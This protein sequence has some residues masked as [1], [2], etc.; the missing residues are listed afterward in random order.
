MTSHDLAAS[1]VM[2]GLEG[3]SV[4]DCFVDAYRRTPFAGVI[5]FGR[6]VESLS[7]VRA[8]TDELRAL[9]T[10]PPL[11]AIDQEGGRVARLRDGVEEL[12]P[13]MALGAARSTELSE[14]AGEQLAFDVRRAG[15][16]ID[17]APVL[18]LAVDARNTVIGA[19]S[20]GSEPRAVATVAR[21][22]LRGM[23]RGGMKGVAKHF[24]GHGATSEDSHLA[25]PVIE[26]SEAVLRERDLAPFEFVAPDVSIMAAHVIARALDPATPASLSHELLTNLLR[27]EWKYDGAVFTDCL[28]MDAIARFFGGT[29]NGAALA[30][31]AGADCA[32]VS[33]GLALAEEAVEEIARRC[34]PERVREARDRLMRLRNA[35]AAPIALDAPAPWPGIG[36]D[37]A[38]AAT[39]LVRGEARMDPATSVVVSFESETTEGAQGTVAEHPRLGG[40]QITLPLEPDAVPNVA[41]RPIIISRRAHIYL[42][43]ARAI[44]RLIEAHPDAMLVS[45]R[46]PFDISLFPQAKHVIAIY[47][48]GEVSMRGLRDVLVDGAPANGTLPVVL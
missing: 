22:F 9:G 41:K 18:D 42:K 10:P 14:R 45:A 27:K 47:G 6:N 30:I 17:F 3:L 29:A 20:F 15:V 38:R 7:Q 31:D 1:V 2:V 28:T 5:L 26:A 12:P 11:I 16:T 13:M 33:H 24:P 37:I 43:Q 4:D 36:R 35:A 25:L 46:E 8:L 39:T 40:E 48:D 23:E 21:A 44:E 19:R 34:K 32:L